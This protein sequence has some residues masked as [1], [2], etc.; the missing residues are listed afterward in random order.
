M[1]IS[2][3]HIMGFRCFKDFE[4][5]FNEHQNI[6]VGNNSVGKSTILDAINLCVSGMHR[7]QPIRNS[8]SSYLFNQDNV[9]EYL[10]SCEEGKTQIGLP[11]ISIEV[12]F[13][14]KD[15]EV[16]ILADFE[17]DFSSVQPG[18]GVRIDIEFDE[19]YKEEY[20]ELCKNP[21]QIKS[22][23][24]E[25]YKCT[26]QTFAR[27]KVTN[28]IM[29][30]HSLLVDTSSVANNRGIVDSY[31]NR[32]IS[33]LLASDDRV[34]LASAFRQMKEDFSDNLSVKEVV[35]KYKDFAQDFSLSLDPSVSTNWESLLV[36]KIKDIPFHYIGKGEQC[37]TKTY[38]ALQ[39][40][41]ER[42]CA[43]LI[44]EP[45]NHL[46][47]AKLNIFLDQIG[48][49]NKNRQIIVTT[50][51]SVVCNK[52]DLGNLILLGGTTP[53]YFNAI[54]ESTR[55]FFTKLSGYDTLRVVLS[56]KAI[57]VEG[58]CDDLI[59]QRAYKDKFGKL[60]IQD[61]IDIISVSGL[62][63]KRYLTLVKGMSKQ[64]AII[65]DN[66]GKSQKKHEWYDNDQTE[67]IRFFISDDDNAKTLEP[68]IIAANNDNLDKLCKIVDYNGECDA[69]VLAEFMQKN[70]TDSALSIFE[71]EDSITIPQYIQEAITW[72]KTDIL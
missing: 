30:M 29:P 28:R 64:I 36:A 34:T 21:A 24:I 15:D 1:Y 22:L 67:T 42:P 58:P 25:Y 40:R 14:G 13:D 10:K 55:A 70:K 51:S 65:T 9:T 60:P 33:D 63:F 62:S 26:R 7:G 45:E 38:M 66:D 43:L 49:R 50:H 59:V 8:L 47:H 69:V 16:G 52:L 68:Q 41:S 44:E 17:G 54:E 31:L 61:G 35:D 18:Q 53:I 6:L 39:P 5:K 19:E 3:L 72:I 37:M 11:K 4:I 2:K 48:E 57:L 46:S 12:F 56:N 32:M 27:N 23:P 71:A 20:E